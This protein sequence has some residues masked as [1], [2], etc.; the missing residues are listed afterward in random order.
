MDSKQ[1]YMAYAF[2]SMSEH[3]TGDANFAVRSK[4]LSLRNWHVWVLRHPELTKLLKTILC[5]KR[6]NMV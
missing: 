5:V 4:H 6:S 1:C 3:A 2:K